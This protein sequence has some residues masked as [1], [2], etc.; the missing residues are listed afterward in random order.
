MQSLGGLAIHKIL[1]KLGP[2]E[3]A[4]VGCVS[5]H[6][7]EWASDESLWSQFCAQELHLSSPQDPFG[8]LAPSFKVLSVVRFNFMPV[9]VCVCASLM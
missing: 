4:V 2:K 1:S 6:F 9:C 5:H 3:T 7:Q 8:N